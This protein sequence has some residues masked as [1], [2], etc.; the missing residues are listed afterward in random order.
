MKEELNKIPVPH[1]TNIQLNR[2]NSSSPSSQNSKRPRTLIV[3]ST[4]IDEIKDEIKEGRKNIISEISKLTISIDNLAKNI[5]A[6]VEKNSSGNNSKKDSLNQSLS[7]N[8]SKN[9]SS[10]A[11]YR[12]RDIDKKNGE[13]EESS[14]QNKGKTGSKFKVVV[15]YDNY[16][17]KK[18]NK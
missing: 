6:L 1:Q 14:M 5:G 2:I 7:S 9:S 17:K 10:T 16:I 13:K 15:N 3:A 4:D 18:K 8:W 12:R 11:F